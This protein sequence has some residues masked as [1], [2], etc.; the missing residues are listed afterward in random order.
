MVRWYRGTHRIEGLQGEWK[1]GKNGLG[2]SCELSTFKKAS[3]QS[4][5]K[6][7]SEKLKSMWQV[8]RGFTIDSGAADH[9]MPVGWVNS[10]KKEES[11]GSKKG[12]HY[13]AA[14]GQRIPNVG[15]QRVPFQP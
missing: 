13:V 11:E 6:R 1:H 12:L 2:L 15:Q 5:L 14:S 4:Y 9:V 3:Q 7:L 8:H 10:V